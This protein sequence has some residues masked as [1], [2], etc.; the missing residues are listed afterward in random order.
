[1]TDE[2]HSIAYQRVG[3]STRNQILPLPFCLLVTS[4]RSPR[5]S[6]TS[7]DGV[8]TMHLRSGRPRV[9]AKD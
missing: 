5:V 3:S 6:L 8:S 2:A 9:R 4:G 1:M 7:R